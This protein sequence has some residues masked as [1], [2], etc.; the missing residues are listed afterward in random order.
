MKLDSF[1]NEICEL[2]RQ[3]DKGSKPATHEIRKYSATLIYKKYMNIEDV[4]DQINWTNPNMFYQHY[5]IENYDP[6]DLPEIR[7]PG[8]FT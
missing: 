7:I 3:G 4:T 8:T 1:S 2:I 6:V 5:L